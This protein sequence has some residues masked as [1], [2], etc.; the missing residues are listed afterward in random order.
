M[1]LNNRGLATSFI[2]LIF[3]LIILGVYYLMHHSLNGIID[4][5][6]LIYGISYVGIGTYFAVVYLKKNNKHFNPNN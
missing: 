2:L 5:N 1:K 3:L 6:N 4:V